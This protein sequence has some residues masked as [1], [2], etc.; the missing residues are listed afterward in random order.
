[1]LYSPILTHIE[2]YKARNMLDGGLNQE[3]PR[4]RTDIKN[5]RSS[6]H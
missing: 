3:V 6:S 5:T 1:M 4:L 2:V